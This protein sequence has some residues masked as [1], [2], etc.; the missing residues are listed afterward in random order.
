MQ[1]RFGNFSFAYGNNRYVRY[2]P[3]NVR[4]KVLEARRWEV[5]AWARDRTI[6]PTIVQEVAGNAL[7]LGRIPDLGGLGLSYDDTEALAHFVKNTFLNMEDAA[8]DSDYLEEEGEDCPD[9]EY[10]QMVFGRPGKCQKKKGDEP[11]EDDDAKKNEALVK[12]LV[13]IGEALYDLE[14]PEDD[15]NDGDSDEI[16][17]LAAGLMKLVKSDGRESVIDAVGDIEDELSMAYGA[18]DFSLRSKVQSKLGYAWDAAEEESYPPIDEPFDEYRARA[19]AVDV[20]SEDADCEG[21]WLGEAS[22]VHD[23]GSEIVSAFDNTPKDYAK[24]VL[25]MRNPGKGSSGSTFLRKQT[26]AG[27]KKAKWKP[28]KH[29]SIKGPAE[30]YIA[31]IPG[32]MG[33][34]KI[35]SLPANAKVKLV[36]PKNTGKVSAEVYGVPGEKVNFT[37]A[38]VGPGD[39]GKV[40]WTLFPGAPIAPSEIAAKGKVGQTVTPKQAKKLGFD[41]AKVAA[42][43]SAYSPE[44]MDEAASS[45]D[46]ML[47][48]AIAFAEKYKKSYDFAESL[49]WLRRGDV[50]QAQRDWWHNTSPTRLGADRGKLRKPHY[51]R[52]SFMLGL[53][54]GA[55][56]VKK[57]KGV[58]TEDCDNLDEKRD[59]SNWAP[60]GGKAVE[61]NPAGA[62]DEDSVWLYLNGK[63]TLHLSKKEAR[64]LRSAMCRIRVEDQAAFVEALLDED[65]RR[66]SYTSRTT[67]KSY[68]FRQKEAFY[69]EKDED[70]LVWNLKDSYKAMKAADSMGDEIASGYYADDLH[71]ISKV[72]KAKGF[73]I[74]RR[75]K[76]NTDDDLVRRQRSVTADPDDPAAYAKLRRAKQ[77]LGMKVSAF[78]K[79]RRPG[80]P[81]IEDK[82]EHKKAKQW[83]DLAADG[84]V[85]GRMS[86][87]LYNMHRKIQQN[88][89][90]RVKKGQYDRAKMDKGWLHWIEAA[91]SVYVKDEY[92]GSADHNPYG[93]FSGYR[94]PTIK[95]V[96]NAGFPKKYR[97]YLASLFT[98]EFES[99]YDNEYI[100]ESVG[101]FEDCER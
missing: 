86:Q 93:S 90:K 99:D 62:Y 79:P 74:P 57:P 35:S 39:G 31:K 14:D 29:S 6:D 26:W 48:Q 36:D 70:S 94:Y 88:S 18:E 60:T 16:F 59:Y 58:W 92:S 52:F 81:P 73:K 54:N 66:G 84:N 23:H 44:F 91:L 32:R 64:K 28:Y 45:K 42:K 87:N 5:D 100:E 40:I 46:S 69:K 43:S 51:K 53:L 50:K 101:H 7:R 25:G 63:K 68:P 55:N 65:T 95:Q 89:V 98:N 19:K 24:K 78:P 17:E 33:L 20:Y 83:L 49:T 61:F 97:R 77:R 34:V 4:S 37:V 22:G 3:D 21:E 15:F 72:M 76:E 56:Y 9:G 13:K 47:K 8:C 82:V 80:Q 2:W 11:E 38:L 85:G 30:G 1:K 67:K 75:L 12:G 27:L 96:T 71:T 10:R 41:Y